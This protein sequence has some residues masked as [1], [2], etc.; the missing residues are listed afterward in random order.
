MK[1]RMEVFSVD[2]AISQITKPMEAQLSGQ[3]LILPLSKSVSMGGYRKQRM[4]K[5]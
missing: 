2:S 4:I 5:K 3:K 1:T